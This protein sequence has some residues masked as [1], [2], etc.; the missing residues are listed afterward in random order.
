MRSNKLSGYKSKGF[1]KSSRPF[2]RSKKSQIY[3]VGLIIAIIFALVGS[4]IIINFMT[5][6]KSNEEYLGTYESGMIDAIMEGDN[7]LIYID[8]AAEYSSS[9][10]FQEFAKN[11]G[12]TISNE[13]GEEGITKC[14]TYVYNLWNSESETCYP[15]YK[16]SLVQ[17][18]FK[19]M[20]PRLQKSTD[21][22]MQK[23]TPFDFKYSMAT[24]KES[25]ISALSDMQYEY[26]VFKE[27]KYKQDPAVQAY[28]Q[29]KQTY[30][31]STFNVGSGNCQDIANFAG[32]Y[33]GVSWTKNT[34]PQPPDKARST[35]LQCGAFVT[36]VFMFGSSMAAPMG[37]GNEKCYNFRT[38]TASPTVELLYKR[39]T[40]YNCITSVSCM[41]QLNSLTEAE[42][43]TLKLTPGDIFSSTTPT[44][45]GH[46]YGHTGIYV[47]KGRLENPKGGSG[48]QY[49]KFIQDPNGRHVAIH[50]GVAYSYIT[51]LETNNRK[52]IAFCRHK[53][54]ITNSNPVNLAQCQTN[55]NPDWK[56][57]NIQVSNK[58]VTGD[59]TIKIIT[60]IENPN[61]E[62]V[63][64]AAKPSFTPQGNT[65]NLGYVFDT[66]KKVDVYRDNSG[67]N[68]KNIEVECRFITDPNKL[69]S[70]RGKDK[71]VLLAPN[72][73]TN[74]KYTIE[75]RAYD[76]KLRPVQGSTVEFEVSKPVG[77]VTQSN[78]TQGAKLIHDFSML[79]TDDEFTD[80][81][82]TQADIQK[83]LEKKGS[84][85]KD[86]VDGKI[87]SKII[88][89]L[90]KK[91]NINPALI[92]TTLQKEQSLITA[93]TASKDKLN[94]ATGC[95]CPDVKKCDPKYFG[96]ENQIKCAI[97]SVY[98]KHFNKGRTQN[99]PF[100]MT[101]INY[102][103]KCPKNSNTG[104]D[105]IAISNAAT[106]ALYKYTPHTYDICLGN[107]KLGGG[108]YLFL[109]TMKDYYKELTG[110]EYGTGSGSINQQYQQVAIDEIE[111]KGIIGKYYIK[112]SFNVNIP[113]DLSLIDNLSK[114]MNYTSNDCRV[115]TLSKS[116]CL[117]AKITEFNANTGKHY[118]DNGVK[119]ELSRDCDEFA[120]QKNFNEFMESVE[121]CALSPDFDCQCNL[122]KSGSV[123]I[124]IEG[125]NDSAL[126][127]FEKSGITYEVNSYNKFVDANNN[128][129]KLESS[130]GSINLYKKL[131]YLKSGTTNYKQCAPVESRFRLCLKT[132]Y[133][134]EEYNGRNLEKKNVTIKFAITIKDNDAPPPLTGLE[135]LNKKH[136]RN[137]V[138][139]V[140]DESKKN[141][142]RVPDV[143]SYTIYMSD[144]AADFAGDIY[145]LRTTGKYR[146]L[147][148]LTTGHEKLASFDYLQEPE[149]ELVNSE[150]CNFKYSAKDKDGNDIKFELSEDKL[151]Y[152]MDKEKFL[153]VLDGSDSYNDLKI[154]RDKY[155]AVT[156]IDT[157]GNEI[158]NLDITQKIT[159]GQ[160][161]NNIVPTD[162]LEPGFVFLN[163]NVI[164]NKI[165]LTYAAPK[166]YING[167]PMDNALIT[168]RA[169]VDWTCTNQNPNFCN[170]KMPFN[171]ISD[172][173]DLQ[174]ELDK[175]TIGIIG[176]IPDIKKNSIDAQYNWAF[177]VIP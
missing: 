8:Q 77:A 71:C 47:G 33:I 23:E 120:E 149:C 130:I 73:N 119:I 171:S 75:A 46:P 1:G 152:I 93:K 106:Y 110:I 80:T 150:Y 26:Y 62:C 52:M 9:E 121:N 133:K 162:N 86:P 39:N 135:L 89:D 87:P 12:V 45:Y 94:I 3:I 100:E 36:S 66:D 175:N 65:Y 78:I 84:V 127:S 139:V 85:L 138:I 168:Y 141:G 92:L 174:I 30:T 117:N 96:F 61:K 172:T 13:Q 31:G 72:D 21:I 16:E 104:V 105:K 144:I 111:S 35:G 160:N 113:F 156:A 15:D 68:Y 29:N 69:N 165:Y 95:G 44:S 37:N 11:G 157:D 146:S 67:R 5:R 20:I 147:D 176:V 177:T 4:F 53:A 64:V 34:I 140:F 18:M 48:W 99:Y 102:G 74:I 125:N 132:D 83:F 38:N 41:T 14:K 90:C 59:E 161:L 32:N 109:E 7:A 159:Q 124:K 169:Y 60:T 123:K 6:E 134:T 98:I 50:S 108:N 131:G 164:N 55:D 79:I 56:I 81:S 76:S 122:V 173:G 70:E 155:I 54:C 58:Q 151:Y 103:G 2:S 148:V 10:A 129:L 88:Y 49:T 158:N 40:D 27:K 24:I 154:G 25:T 115:S 42:L 142:V 97:E 167:E 43:D 114:F 51:D 82:L 137:S 17:Y 153:Y 22:N 128:A 170:V 166:F 118:A 163:S 19:S 116:D 145:L 112:P 28:V 107:G 126:M 63:S 143:A 91:N 101:G 57:T 136:S